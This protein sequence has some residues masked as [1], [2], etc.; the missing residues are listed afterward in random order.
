MTKDVKIIKQ[1]L[2]KC[3]FIKSGTGIK[4]IHEH[5]FSCVYREYITQWLAM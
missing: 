4:G 3:S 2:G 1:T 5:M